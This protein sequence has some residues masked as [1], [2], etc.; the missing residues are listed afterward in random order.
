MALVTPRDDALLSQRAIYDERFSAGAYDHRSAVRV[1]TAERDALN[2]AISRALKSHP[3]ARRLSLFDFGYG[4]GRVTND[5]AG[6]YTGQQDL[7]VAAYDV[8]SVGLRKAA[9]ELCSAGFEPAGSLAWAPDSDVGY[10]AGSVCR[11]EAGVRVTV[12][13]I[14]GCENESPEV[15]SQ[16]AVTANGGE[17]Y[18]VTTSWYSGIGHVPSEAL[19]RDYFR[20]L[21]DLTSPAGEI[22]IAM[23]STGDLVELQQEWARKL[24]DGA[25]SDFPVAMPGDVVYDTELG[26]ANYYHVFSTDLDGHMDAITGSGQHWWVEGIRYPDEEFES[27]A[28]EQDNYQRVRKANERNRGRRWAA[29]DYREFHTVAAFRSPEPP[30]AA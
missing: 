24:A 12:V 6:Q 2:G 13:F 10:I 5:L 1:L 28:A 18:L 21:S 20:G 16:L 8:A 30:A 11:E 17:R 9:A 7:L 29:D 23:S 4:T 22:V 15:M 27:H 19:R 14:H 25:T 26:Q 3:D